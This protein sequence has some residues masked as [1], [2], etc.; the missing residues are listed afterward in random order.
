MHLSAVAST[1]SR[2]SR[3]SSSSA[4]RLRATSCRRPLRDGQRPDSRTSS[5][6]RPLHLRCWSTFP[7]THFRAQ[8]PATQY[9][10]RSR[11][12]RG[13][14]ASSTSRLRRGSRS[15]Q[16]SVGDVVRQAA[17]RAACQTCQPPTILQTTW[18]CSQWWVLCHDFTV[19]H[20]VFSGLEVLQCF[21]AVSSAT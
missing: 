13:S 21:D 5:A 19:S 3:A 8:Y 2:V 18:F 10:R 16:P 7:G 11:W 17:V 1:V 20:F 4:D 12:W 14:E 6:R 15:R 9:C